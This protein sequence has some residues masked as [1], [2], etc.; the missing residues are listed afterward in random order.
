MLLMLLY[1]NNL[2]VNISF[3]EGKSWEQRMP[4]YNNPSVANAA[5]YSDMVNLD[6]YSIGVFV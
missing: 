6:S 2:T 1:R 5:A 3:D 4:I